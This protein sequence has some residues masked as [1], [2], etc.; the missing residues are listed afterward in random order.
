MIR[1]SRRKTMPS[2]LGR[3]D[4]GPCDTAKLGFEIIT[5]ILMP[6]SG[7]V[8]HSKSFLSHKCRSNCHLAVDISF[9]VERLVL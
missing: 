5:G 7:A 1:K 9:S 8:S 6:Q 2:G 4:P 3:V